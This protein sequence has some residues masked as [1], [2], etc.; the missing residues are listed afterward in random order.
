MT[1]YI[2][3]NMAMAMQYSNQQGMDPSNRYGSGILSLADGGFIGGG[4]IQGQA[5]PGGRT[6]F[7]I[8]KKLKKMLCPEATQDLKLNTKNRDASIKAEHIQYGPLNVSEPGDYW[9]DIADYW[10]TTV[11]AAKKSVCANCTAFDISPRMDEC[12]PGPTSDGEGRLGYCWMHHFKCHS[13]R[14]C[15]TWAKGGPIKE[16]K[17]SK[18]WQR[19]YE[20]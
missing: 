13:A 4:N 6:G 11:K 16:D 3:P 8:L 19:K 7:G 17:I 14:A 10:N 18:E 15:R 2:A 20:K 12:M 9:K 1:Q 5:M